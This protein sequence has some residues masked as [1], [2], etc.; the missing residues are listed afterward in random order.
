[1]NR[2]GAIVGRRCPECLKGKVFTGA[3]RMHE[4]CAVCGF[5]FQ[6]EPGYYVGAMYFSY[7]LGLA[8]GIPVFFGT[9]WL[10]W[11]YWRGIA[12]TAGVLV[13]SSPLLFQYSRVMWL[14]FER[15][16]GSW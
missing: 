4:R 14:H 12:V 9:W 10:G 6:R 8:L 15:S 1:M 11:S 13:G 5:A 7:A 2:L 16:L 3:W